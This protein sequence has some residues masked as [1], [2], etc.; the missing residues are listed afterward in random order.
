M[1]QRSIWIDYCKILLIYF[2]IVAHSNQIPRIADIL[3][4]SFHMPAFF[5][6]SGYLYKS[7]DNLWKSI[8]KNALRL[9]VPALFFSFLCSLI[10]DVALYKNGVLTLETGLIKP[11]IGL[12]Y[13]DSEIGMPAC[14]VIWFLIVLFLSKIALDAL[15]KYF[16][17]K[18]VAGIILGIVVIASLI[19]IGNFTYLYL[20]ERTMVSLPFVYWGYLMRKYQVLEKVLRLKCKYFILGGGILVYLILFP[21]NGRVGIHSFVFGYSLWLFYFIA[22]LASLLLFG[23]SM[24]VCQKESKLIIW[25]SSNTMTILCLHRVLLGVS[26]HFLHE[27]FSQSLIVLVL[28]MPIIWVLN[29]FC[30]VLIGNKK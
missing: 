13:Y 7:N 21:I 5:M 29:K 2:V 9:L 6:I 15:F 30:P 4:C 12:I 24:I 18:V 22:L 10:M 8:K 28:L 20:L 16:S 27:G 3:I 14:G 26:S 23:F 1:K 19:K 11:I 17:G 25:L